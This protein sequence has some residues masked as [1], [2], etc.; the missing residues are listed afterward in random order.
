[1]IEIK[2]VSKSFGDVQ[3]LDNI[4]CTI[5]SGAVFGI[6]GSNGAGKS[7][8]LRLISGVYDIL[9]GSISFDG[10]KRED[11]VE[12]IPNL[13]F[14]SDEVYFESADTIDIVTK[15][16]KNIYTDFDNEKFKKLLTVFKMKKTDRMMKLSKGMKK[17]VFLS[18][19]L[20][21]GIKYLLLDE[22]LDGLDPLMR[23]NIKKL[24]FDET[25][26]NNMT[27][28][29]TSH[30]LKELED[31]CDGLAMI[32]DGEIV[33]QGDLEDIK[34]NLVKIRCA[35]NGEVSEET[36]KE[37]DMI[38]YEKSGKIIT[39]IVRGDEAEQMERVNKLKPILVETLP[40]TVE[41]VFISRLRRLGYGSMEVMEEVL[42]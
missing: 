23:I 35:F 37:F 20:S 34:N 5:K 15:R 16:Y 8:L 25:A 9:S 24:I 14:L 22:T 19:A 1:M 32:H 18:I 29:V 6:V 28:I 42:K 39:I 13:L 31:I 21:C 12:S 11:K 10:V 17:Q 2:N 36:F 30:S 26:R 7:T 27:T 33:I 4:T 3:V 41:E 40:I 38:G